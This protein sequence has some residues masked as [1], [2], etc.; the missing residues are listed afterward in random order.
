MLEKN[1]ALNIKMFWVDTFY[2]ENNVREEAEKNSAT[3]GYS[4]W[5]AEIGTETDKH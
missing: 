2:V 3:A 1:R 4:C 5:I